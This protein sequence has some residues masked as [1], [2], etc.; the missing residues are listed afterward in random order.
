MSWPDIRS[1]I[2]HSGAMVLLD[3]VIAIDEETLCAEVLIGPDSLF[4]SAEGVGAWVGLEY[5]AQTIAAFAGYTA[6]LRGEAVK[7]GFLLG[8]RRYECTL[9]VFSVG[10]LL[11]VHVRRV[12]QSENGLGSFQCR[13]EHGEEEVATA[14]LTVFQ[15]ADARDFVKGD[16]NE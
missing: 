6:S 11:K 1:L 13:I 4:G 8:A 12:L 7:P 15:P 3:R 5:M 10:S 9:P 14:M 16:S 2:P